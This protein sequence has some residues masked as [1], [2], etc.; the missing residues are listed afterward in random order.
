VVSCGQLLEWWTYDS[1]FCV[2]ASLTMT[3]VAALISDIVGLAIMALVVVNRIRYR[4]DGGRKSREIAEAL[5]GRVI[6]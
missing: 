1:R 4:G 6:Y 2:R 5:V 3:S